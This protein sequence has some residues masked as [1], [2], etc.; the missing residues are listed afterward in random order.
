MNCV[1][2]VRPGGTIC[3]VG[4][5]SEG[6]N[7]LLPR[8]RW[9][10]G[11]GGKGHQLGAVLR[12]QP[13]HVAAAA[14]ARQRPDR[15]EILRRHLVDG[16]PVTSPDHL[17]GI[18]ASTIQRWVSQLF[19]SALRGF[20]GEDAPVEAEPPADRASTCTQI[21]DRGYA[22]VRSTSVDRAPGGRSHASFV[23]IEAPR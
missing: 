23:A 7:V 22:G 12:R 11:M 15:C 18:D 9:G 10:V 16:V 13:A 6:D 5:H 4:Y 20:Q 14:V 3:N 1:R 17:H 21:V 8:L 19:A 2:A